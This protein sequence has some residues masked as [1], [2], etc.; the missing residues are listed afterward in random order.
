[1]MIDATAELVLLEG[2]LR[3]SAAQQTALVRAPYRITQVTTLDEALPTLEARHPA[4]ILLGVRGTAEAV[5]TLAHHIARVGLPTRII[6]L[7]AHPTVRG[8][9][10]ALQWGASEYIGRHCSPANLVA[11]VRRAL[12]L[13]TGPMRAMHLLAADAQQS[14]GDPIKQAALRDKDDLISLVSHELRTPLMAVSGYL[15]ILQKHHAKLSREKTLD[16]IGRS[17]QATSELAYLSDML[18]QV[19]QF[20]AGRITPRFS[21]VAVAPLVRAAIDQSDLSV[22]NHIITCDIAADLLVHADIMALQ[23]IIRNLLSNAIKYSPQGGTITIAAQRTTGTLMELT[24]HDEGIGIATDQLPHLF[25]RFARVH[26]AGQW[27]S[28]RGT[29]LGLYICRQLVAAHGGHIW[30]E[31]TLGQGSTFHLRLPLAITDDPTLYYRNVTWHD[32][33]DLAM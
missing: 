30:A 10:T 32:S 1:M 22:T 12:A 29:G 33:N 2:D 31:S 24:V 4:A 25:E 15:E 19:L 9:T 27:P 28:I 13:P 21:A 7:A 20:E 18:V 26:D 17:L 6:V 3:L 16:F 11:A 14:G 5:Q 8:A 23:Q